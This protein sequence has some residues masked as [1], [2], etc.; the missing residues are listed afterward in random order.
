MH[1]TGTIWRPPY[2]A[3]SLLLEVTA[4]CTH[5]RC[6]FCTLYRE[7]PFPFRMSPLETVEA[8][9]LEAQT[10]MRSLREGELLLR[11]L[12]ERPQIK[13][14]FLTGGNPF[15]LEFRR[16]RRIGEL[17][18]QYFPECE[19][20]GCFAR[21]T[22]VAHKSGEELEQLARLGYNGIS[23]G[24]ETGD[25][26]ALAFM[27]K[28][29]EAADI[30]RE[31]KRLEEAGIGYHF[32][33]LA[34][35]AGAGRGKEAAK[36]SAALFNQTRPGIIGSSML[37]VF[38]D[39]RLQGEIQAGNWREAGELEKLEELRALVEELSIP[40]W[41]ATLGSSNAVFV[42]GRLP[43][44]RQRLLGELDHALAKG[45][46]GALRSYREDFTAAGW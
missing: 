23:I 35:I 27:D 8:D 43:E 40:V 19:T 29:Y 37:T 2:E 39:S 44:E 21:V 16:L 31:T 42:E 18:R 1:Y 7:L 11:G 25:D 15:A 24:V 38:P 32:L 30:L 34:G 14:V 28:G 13:R 45:S 12:G 6:K 5:H 4:G 22:D 26:K 9:L 20:I 41:F 17:V 3:G 10:A 46:E 36:R 33:Y